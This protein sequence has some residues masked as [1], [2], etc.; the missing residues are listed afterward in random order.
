MLRNIIGPLFNFNLDHFFGILLFF[1]FA[2]TP[3]FI[4]FSTKNAKLKD[5]Q[6]RNKDTICEHNCANSFCQNVRFFCFCIFH[7]CCVS[8]VHFFIRDV[9]WQVS[10][11][12]KNNK[13]AKQEEQKNNN[14]QKTRCK[15]KRNEMLWFKT[16]QD[17]K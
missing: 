8:N 13:I 16:T 6:K 12:Q 1:V 11:N 7:F 2:E 10:K 15:A 9:L 3:I 17:N 5:T 4:V 14:N